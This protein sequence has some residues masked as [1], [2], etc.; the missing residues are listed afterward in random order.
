MRKS[1]LPFVGATDAST[2]FG[3]G[4]TVAP[5]PLEQ[6]KALSRLCAKAG[7]YIAL[8]RSND[9][10]QCGHREAVRLGPRHQLGCTFADFEV[11][12]SVKV[13]DPG[14]VN[15][16]EARAL[17]RYIRW[18]LRSTDRLEHWIVVLVDSQVVIGAA[19]KGRSSPMPLNQLMR[20]LA[21]LCFAGG[22]TL[23][24]VFIPSA[25][26][27]ADP[28]PRGG[29]DTWP[30]RLRRASRR[31]VPGGKR[32]CCKRERRETPSFK[33]SSVLYLAKLE[34]QFV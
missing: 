21:A 4:A 11:V 28:P 16:E 5:L 13:D 2:T 24:L 7:E 6:V 27:P 29:P 3:H 18:I 32:Q 23:H 22:L 8:E 33:L 20:C 14:H 26:N 30:L 17:L 10:S 12:L 25:H 31:G 9:E 1:H 15:L 19:I 34:S